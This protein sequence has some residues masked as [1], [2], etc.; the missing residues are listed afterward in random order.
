M[1]RGLI[2]TEGNL[3][4]GSGTLCESPHLSSLSFLLFEIKEL[5]EIIFLGP[6]LTL[7]VCDGMTW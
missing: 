4:C 5:E 3:Q 2:L 7:I 1:A 6:P